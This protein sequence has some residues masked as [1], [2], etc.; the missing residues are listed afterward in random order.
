M[1]LNVVLCLLITALLSPVTEQ[2]VYAQGQDAGTQVLLQ[3]MNQAEGVAAAGATAVPGDA[4]KKPEA[5]APAPVIEELATPAEP[6][7]TAPATEPAPTA[8]PAIEEL[9]TPAEP[10]KTAPAAAPAIEELVPAPAAPATEPAPAAAPAIE[11]LA[12]AP[13]V[14]TPAPKEAP[15]ITPAVVAPA[16]APT[17]A[18]PTG[19]AA[20]K[21]ALEAAVKSFGSDE[22]MK[23]SA[24]VAEQE[25]VRRKARELDGRLAM[26]NA[27]KAVKS[28]DYATAVDQYKIAAEKLKV[29]PH[30][31][32]LRNRAIAQIPECEF[33][34]V[35]KMVKDGHDAEAIAK[36]QEFLKQRPGNLR[37]STLIATLTKPQEKRP[38]PGADVARPG[39]TEIE[40][41]MRLGREFMAK[42]EYN[43]ARERFESVLALDPENREAMRYLKVLGE[44]EYG[45][46]TVERDA[47][48]RKMTAEVREA[49]N[50]KYKVIKGKEG[51]KTKETSPLVNPIEE[52][53][54]KI[55]I[56]NIEWRQANMHDCVEFLNKQS[57]ENDKSTDDESKK[58]I[59][60]IL[61]LGVGAP[62]APKPA[63]GTGTDDVFGG[64]ATGAATPGVPEVTFGARYISLYDVLKTITKMYGLKWQ[65][66]GGV[67]MIV[68][69]DW[70]PE[71]MEMK[72]Y[73]VEPTFI[74][75]VQE[76]STA[77]PTISRIGG[78]DRETMNAGGGSTETVPSDLNGYFEKMGIKFPKGSS[79]TY[80]P[81]IGKVIMVNTEDQLI[82]F[83]KLLSELNVVPKQVEIEARFVEVNETDMYEAGLEWLLTD[84]WEM[85]LKQGSNPYAPATATPRIQM[86]A[87]SADNGFTKGLRFK[88]TEVNASTPIVGG[89]AGSIASIASVLTNPDIT[90][91]LHAL[92]QNGNSDLLSAPKVTTQSGKEAIIKVVTEYIY[93]TAFEMQGGTLNQN[94]NNNTANTIQ[95]TTVM[96]TDFAT[97]EVGVI[98]TVTPEVSPDG[99]M[100]NLKMSPQVVTE[101]TWYQ[102]GSTVRRADGSEQQLNM[103]QPF[104]HLRSLSTEISIYDGATVVMGGL[105]TEALEK[106][107]DKIPILGDIPLIGAL[108]RSKSEK[109]IKKNLLIFVTAKLVDPG[110]QLL[111]KPDQE[112]AKTGGQLAPSGGVSA[113][114][115][116]PAPSPDAVLK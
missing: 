113:P 98:L 13:K 53:M 115:T 62:A 56:E 81:A 37:L 67:V 61:N 107:N 101:P 102:Y 63:A 91:I 87:N 9:A 109:S 59:N 68:P 79:V 58:G 86:N 18:A 29:A 22:R 15:E 34:L 96:P 49:W 74:T 44:R 35:R 17:V 26:D 72:M 31:A 89:T 42:R 65:I 92:E 105:I 40:K 3:E 19:D 114:A 73:P 1:R 93:P 25:S 7:K 84:N 111:K 55:I 85:L 116:T 5:A 20:T 94:N 39:E 70:T 110:G 80:N 32:A 104:F 33:Q 90:M 51:D 2:Q 24:S 8:A 108:F 12:P 36:G 100:I 41:Q 46:R 6:A 16:V 66:D 88:G 60:I 27:D 52:K 76:A 97:R 77:M 54:K 106:V 45:N 11:E 23:V 28:G 99:N 21:E 30:C 43:G 10:A 47:T 38:E 48:A 75:R 57:R 4:E 14:T 50:S 71:T 112:A 83:E 103:P 78:K 64:A 69:V 82:R 95:E